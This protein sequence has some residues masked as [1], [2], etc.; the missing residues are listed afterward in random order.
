[1]ANV[2]QINWKL[3]GWGRRLGIGLALLLIALGCLG[4]Y[5]M[6]RF[7]MFLHHPFD[8]LLL[9]DIL[10]TD[11][12]GFGLLMMLNSRFWGLGFTLFL[13]GGMISSLGSKDKSGAALVIIVLVIYWL[14]RLIKLVVHKIKGLPKIT[15]G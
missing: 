2:F 14:V 13:L 11:F 1:M 15:E 7:M 6:I 8:P 9:H 5:S 3:S 12:L 4:I 10:L